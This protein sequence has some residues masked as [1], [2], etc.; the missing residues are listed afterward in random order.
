[1]RNNN[2]FAL[3]RRLICVPKC[4]SCKKRLPPIVDKDELNHGFPCLCDECMQKWQMARVQMCHTCSKVASAC[5]C[6]PL[7]KTF[8]QPYIPS[9]FFYRP[10]TT[11]AESK[12]VY[13]IKHKDNRDLFDF[14]TVELYPKL[15][16]LF[17][18]LDINA[19][20]CI[21]T[22]IPRT[23]KALV[24][25]GFD[26]GEILCKRMASTANAVCLPLLLRKGGKEQKRLS[27]IQRVKNVEKAIHINK[28]LRGFKKEYR[29]H[30]IEEILSGKTVVIVE[31]II[32]TG[33][34]V[35]RAIKCLKDAGAKNVL[36]CAVAR[37]EISTEKKK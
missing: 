7:K 31:D 37:S 4:A 13:S 26:Q 8:T 12:V 22:Y 20:E 17:C 30:K 11:R 3:L 34:T 6:M 10:D 23:K 19:Q 14:I 36:V 24:Q 16:E 33:A 5:T 28:S 32:T 15:D 1:M 18:E 9:L 29:Q 21:F 25:N 2:K 27:R 35:Q